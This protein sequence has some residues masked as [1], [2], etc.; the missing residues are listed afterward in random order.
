MDSQPKMEDLLARGDKGHNTARGILS[1]IFRQLLLELNITPIMFNKLLNQYLK[2][3][4]NRV[5]KTSK[6]RSSTRGNISKELRKSRMTWANFE[7]GIRFLNP[8]KATFHIRLEW[9]NGRTTNHSI[10]IL[11]KKEPNNTDTDI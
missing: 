8:V 6:G 5:S 3:P 9:K 2:D 7:K 10:T 4:R 1:K 11:D